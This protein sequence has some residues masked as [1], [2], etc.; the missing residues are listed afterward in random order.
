MAHEACKTHFFAP[1]IILYAG[2]Q[3]QANFLFRNPAFWQNPK[4]SATAS[5]VIS[6]EKELKRSLHRGEKTNKN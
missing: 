3:S 5:D 2:F 4:V 1:V 6:V